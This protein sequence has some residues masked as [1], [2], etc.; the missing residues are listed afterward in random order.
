MGG[1]DEV[2]GRWQRD[3]EGFW[4]GASSAIDWDRPP[5]AI[6]DRSRKPSPA[7]FPGGEL[8]TCFNAVDRHV[9]VGVHADLKIV[10]MRILDRLV[11]LLLCHRQDA[12]VVRANIRCAHAH[13][14]L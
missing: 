12:V 8:N 9:A 1:Y 5:E 11:N 13:G 6:I 14:P 10:P 7:W 3:P 2:Y 4:R